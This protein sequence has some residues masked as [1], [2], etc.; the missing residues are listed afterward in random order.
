MTRWIAAVVAALALV[1]AGPVALAHGTP[2]LSS[3]SATVSPGGNVTLSGDGLGAAGD[4]IVIKLVAPNYSKPLDHT[5]TLAADAFD[6]EV[7]VVPADAPLGTAQFVAYK[8]GAGGAE[9][10]LA[11]AEVTI[12]RGSAPSG[13]SAAMAQ[14]GANTLVYHHS[15]GEWIVIVIGALVLA[16][17]AGVLLWPR[18]TSMPD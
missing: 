11:A 4:T 9:T 6:N 3:A 17:L 16:A 5:V 18:P 13:S 15:T 7:F 1:V 8:Q 14:P 10:K 2:T 12:Q